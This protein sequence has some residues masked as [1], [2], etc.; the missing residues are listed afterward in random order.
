MEAAEWEWKWCT[1][2]N[3]EAVVEEGESRSC[4]G[5]WLEVEEGELKSSSCSTESNSEA[6]E[7]EVEAEEAC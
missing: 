4:M 6:V 2:L 1:G 5:Y 7:A 3:W